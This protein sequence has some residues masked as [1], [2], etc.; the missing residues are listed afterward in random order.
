VSAL[1]CREFRCVYAYKC[2]YVVE[3]FG[4]R[5]CV[6]AFFLCVCAITIRTLSTCV[7]ALSL[8]LS[9]CVCARLLALRM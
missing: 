5:M 4:L 3:L 2:V 6:R 9:L 1:V 7:L 8:S